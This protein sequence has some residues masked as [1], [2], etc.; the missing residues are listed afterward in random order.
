MVHIH[1]HTNRS[2]SILTDSPNDFKD[3]I[4]RAKDMGLKG[5]IFTEHGNCISWYHKKKYLEEAGFKYIHAVE[6]YVCEDIESKESYHILVYAINYQG[7]NEI[8]SLITKSYRRDDGHFYKR[9][10]FTIDELLTCNN[11]I[12]STA[13]L[14]GVLNNGTDIIYNKLLQWGVNNK[15]KFFLEIQPHNNEHQIE[16]NKKLIDLSKKYDL[17]LIASNDVHYVDHTY[18]DLRKEMQKSKS[19]NF[20][21]EDSFDLS[22]KTY[23]QMYLEFMNQGLEEDVIKQALDNTDKLYDI[24]SEY[25]M[26]KGFKFPHIYDNPM[27]HM[28]DRCI[29]NFHKRGFD[30]DKRYIDRLMMELNTY[31]KLGAESY[32][33]LFDDWHKGCKDMGIDW[34]FSRGSA[35]GSLVAYLLEITDVDPI[36]WNTSF[37]RFMNE[38]RVTLPD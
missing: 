2:N 9:P 21:E 12:I 25:K 32:M 22:M 31:K 18:G 38:Q 4:G 14:A 35:S 13:C 8:N 5:I 20:E 36:I 10:R 3:Y 16:Y 15:D 23:N 27:K 28:V 19:M 33:L 30:G 17:Q 29:A 26:D 7:K 34:G 11:V 37:S 24:P 1:L 6:G